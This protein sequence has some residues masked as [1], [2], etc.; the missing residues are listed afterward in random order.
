M[1]F[2]ELPDAFL[3]PDGSAV[4]HAR[5]ASIGSRRAALSEG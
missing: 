3:R 1:V 5:R 4:T 2:E